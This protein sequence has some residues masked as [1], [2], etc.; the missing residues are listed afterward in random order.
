MQSS[1]INIS[2]ILKTTKVFSTVGFSTG[3][4][5]DGYK[6]A[7]Y[8]DSLVASSNS[9]PIFSG[10]LLMEQDGD[11]LTI[12][13]GAQRVTTLSLLFFALCQS[14]KGTSQRNEEAGTKLLNTFLLTDG[15][16]KLKLGGVD[17]DV[18]DK[19]IL[20]L[21]LTDEDKN[22]NLYQA[23]ASFLSKIDE[24]KVSP[25]S[26]FN[27]LSTMQFM[28]VITDKSNIPAREIYQVINNRSESQISLVSDFVKQQG[29]GAFGV[30]CDLVGLFDGSNKLLEA[31]IRD[32]L[33]TRLDE[34]VLHKSCLYNSFKSYYFKIIKYQDSLSVMNGM[35]KYALYYL[36]I[37]RADFDKEE[38]REQINLLNEHNGK[39][40]YPYLMEVLDDVENGH[41]EEGAFMN[42]LMMINLFIKSRD[43]I[44]ISN[45][46]IDFANLS[47]ELNKMLVLE[48][49]VP[50][51]LHE[52][53][54]TINEINNLANFEV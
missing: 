11:E 35:Y 27:I 41:I 53:K 44:S 29:N 5:F 28:Q 19:I 20:S 4:A 39:D 18:F 25:N 14:Y 1:V 38:V 51:I 42:I 47:K 50:D 37:V 21:H 23:Y 15:K 34:N 3:Y 26:L 43:E 6:A 9:S 40:T 33:K 7:D 22:S 48:D 46:S 36:K 2:E 16:P 52:N 10:I 30:W 24:K 13:D 12:I 8:F 17:G 32:F 31:F 45:V 49:Y 54:L